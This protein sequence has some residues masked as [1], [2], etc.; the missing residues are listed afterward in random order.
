MQIS[1]VPVMRYGLG[2]YIHPEMHFMTWQGI[3][4]NGH[5]DASDASHAWGLPDGLP[6]QDAMYF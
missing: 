5:Q 6:T 2:A 1:V 3:F 4:P